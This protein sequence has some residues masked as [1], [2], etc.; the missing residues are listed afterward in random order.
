MSRLAVALALAGCCPLAA[1]GAA[2]HHASRCPPREP[3]AGG[4]ATCAVQRPGLRARITADDAPQ[5]WLR[6]ER[7]QEERTQAAAEWSNTPSQQAVDVPGV[8]AGAFWVPAT[9]ELVASDGRRLLTVRV[10]RGTRGDAARLARAG[11]GP[12]HVPA[13]TGP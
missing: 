7:A 5:A 1:C 12:A 3:G 4:V 11:L 6:W 13:R 10:L 9:R 2:A 8:S